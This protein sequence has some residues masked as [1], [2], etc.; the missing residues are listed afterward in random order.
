[1]DELTEASPARLRWNPLGAAAPMH[2]ERRN[3]SPQIE[4]R[5]QPHELRTGV[6]AV[7]NADI[8]NLDGCALSALI[9]ARRISCVEVATVYLDHIERT[10]PAY[11]AIVSLRDR[12]EVLAQAREKDGL[13]ARGMR[14]GWMHGFPQAVKD[15][16]AT[17]GLRT[18]LGSPLHRESIPVRDALFVERTKQSGAIVIGKTN[19]AEFGLGSQTYNPVFGTTLNA[20]DRTCTAG[21]SSGGAAVSLA[22]RM[23]PVADGSD[24]AGSIRNP[25]A[26][27]NVYALRPTQGKIPSEGRDVCLP[28]LGTV[29]PMA[30]TVDDLAMLLAVQAG[31]DR[32]SLTSARDSAAR[33]QEPL[34]RDFRETRIGWLGDFDGYLAFESGVLSLCEKALSVF[35]DIGC[36]VET[37]RIDHPLEQLWNSW[38]ALRA[39]LTGG[40][41]AARFSDPAKRAL[42]K[43]EACWEVE[44]ALRLSAMDVF[45]ASSQRAAWCRTVARLFETFD[46][47]VLPTAQCF[48]F[49]AGLTWPRTIGGRSM[50]TYHRWMEVVIPATMAGCP[51]VNVPAGF[52]ANGLPMGLQILAPCHQDLACLQLA[53][54]YE[55][56][57]NWNSMLPPHPFAASRGRIDGS[58]CS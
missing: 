45:E 9:A 47:L 7:A 30:R 2:G 54:S 46:F 52:S 22:M 36:V 12:D 14:Q 57:T 58:S 53:R 24:N 13:L 20:F 49:D 3:I 55:R 10:N 28:S 27:N 34:K 37:I 43:E 11:N 16:A 38:M 40:S 8:L 1:M 6:A 51:A 23:L 19:T 33:I 17:R 26:F 25:A 4:D 15:L 56:A 35:A 42:M 32:L 21:G 39:W 48:P 18:T 31:Y 5:A 44:R 50:D 29:G 41:L